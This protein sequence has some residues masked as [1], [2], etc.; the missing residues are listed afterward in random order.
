MAVTIVTRTSKAK[1][2]VGDKP[3]KAAF[4]YRKI[5]TPGTKRGGK[6]EAANAAIPQLADCV[7]LVKG[8]VEIGV[9]AEGNMT[10]DDSL[11]GYFVIGW[12]LVENQRQSAAAGNT[13][14]VKVNKVAG[15][16]KDLARTLG[17]SSDKALEMVM[18]SL[19]K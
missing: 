12:N 10:E 18:A 2:A 16:V 1:A 11:V 7:D 15:L 4:D 17:I 14:E 3:A 6:E 8:Q 19:G 13:P 5:I 9:D